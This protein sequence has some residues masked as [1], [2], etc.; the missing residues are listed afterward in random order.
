MNRLLA[1]TLL[2]VLGVA[3]SPGPAVAGAAAGSAA[4]AFRLQDQD[5]RWV[6]LADQRGRWVVLYFY[7]MDDTPG[8]TT[9]ACEFRDNIFA[10][11]R[12]G[13]SVLGVSVQDVASKKA[14]AT[15]HGLPF[16][17]LAD[18]D[19]SVAKAYDVLS[20]MG[21]AKRETFIIDPLGTITRHYAAVDP[22]TH[23]TQLLA[24]LGALIRPAAAP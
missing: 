18:T 19:K 16:P 22:N 24:D 17:L 8:C 12:L 10:F 14:F 1:V 2:T 15:K 9:E 6:S 20:P 3:V 4:P 5:G 7:P 13:V 21:F 11:R 23:S